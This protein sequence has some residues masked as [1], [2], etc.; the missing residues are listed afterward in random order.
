MTIVNGGEGNDTLRGGGGND[1]IYGDPGA[2]KLY[3]D[4]G[5]DGLIGG[6]GADILWGGAGADTFNYFDVNDSLPGDFDVIR[7]FSHAEADTISLTNVFSDVL[8][9][10]GTDPFQNTGGEVRIVAFTNYQEVRVNL[11]TD[12]Q[13]EMIMRVTTTIPLVASD[14]YL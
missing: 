6:Q 1:S 10:R 3:G 12:A 11:D 4:A 2:D 8:V 5:D 7:D 9:F 14:F 13:A